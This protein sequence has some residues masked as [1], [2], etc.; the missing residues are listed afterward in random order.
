ME[1][2][3]DLLGNKPLEEQEHIIQH[4]HTLQMDPVE[5]EVY[6]NRLVWAQFKVAPYFP[7]SLEA[8]YAYRSPGIPPF[9]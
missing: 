5:R 6:E 9:R 1:D 2:L 3:K 4:L 7:T 8:R